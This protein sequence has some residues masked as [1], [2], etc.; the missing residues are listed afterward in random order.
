MGNWR[1]SL[2][3]AIRNLLIGTTDIKSLVG[4]RCYIGEL[5]SIQRPAL[6]CITFKIIIS[7]GFLEFHRGNMRFWVWAETHD[8]ASTIFEKLEATLNHAL[9]NETLININME[10]NYDTDEYFD[11]ETKLY[12]RVGSFA[13]R[14][15]EAAT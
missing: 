14:A 4:A 15:T 13:F 11:T 9:L 7:S 6:P 8:S 10:A 2:E 1:N 12:A 3:I 5:A